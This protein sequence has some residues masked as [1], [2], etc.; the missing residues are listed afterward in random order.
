MSLLDEARAL[1]IGKPR[2][3]VGQLIE[4]LGPGEKAELEEAL[5]A[6]VFATSLATALKARGHTVS[7]ESLQR[8]RRG[9]CQC[10]S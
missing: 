3:S 2:C 5:A 4:S 8:H 7:A 10:L 6:S 1:P 9:G